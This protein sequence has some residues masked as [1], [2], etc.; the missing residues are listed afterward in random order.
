MILTSVCHNI[1]CLYPSM[2]TLHSTLLRQHT[3]HCTGIVLECRGTADINKM[4]KKYK[5]RVYRSLARQVSF[6]FFLFFFF[7]IYLYILLFH[8]CFLC[9]YKINRRH[10]SVAAVNKSRCSVHSVFFSFFLFFLSFI[11]VYLI[12]SYIDCHYHVG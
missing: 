5:N 7:R 11:A 1:L 6:C 3:S 10:T 4:I 2:S 9:G 12:S 8:F